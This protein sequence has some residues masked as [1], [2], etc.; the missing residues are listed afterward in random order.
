MV[1]WKADEKAV[2]LAGWL[3]EHWV[4]QMGKLMVGMKGGNWVVWMGVRMVG[5]LV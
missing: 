4:A 3:A 1:V 2:D 5:M